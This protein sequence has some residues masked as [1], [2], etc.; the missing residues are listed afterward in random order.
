MMTDLMVDIETMGTGANSAIVQIGASYFNRSNGMLGNTFKINIDLND[1]GKQ[2]F[3]VTTETI[4]WWMQQNNKTFL[5]APESVDACLRRFQDFCGDARLYKM[6]VWAHA[7]FDFPILQNAYKKMGIADPFRYT[8]TRDIRT[9]MDLAG[10]AP[11][12]MTGTSRKH[13]TLWRIAF[14]KSNTAAKRLKF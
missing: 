2:G 14:S 7:S 6:S 8:M 10:H 13:M 5:A 3:K 4:L 9:L 1:S 12:K 11:K